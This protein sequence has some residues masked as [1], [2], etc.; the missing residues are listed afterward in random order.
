[1]FAQFPDCL[2]QGVVQNP[3]VSR[4][5]NEVKTLTIEFDTLLHSR[6]QAPKRLPVPGG[7]GA[8]AGDRVGEGLRTEF[9]GNTE[10]NRE[11]E[12]PDPQAVDAWERGDGVGVFDA[13]RCL[14]LAK[15]RASPVGCGEL[16]F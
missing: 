14:D 5:T 4:V 13:F 2:G 12:M 15:Q 1:A 10:R 7:G 3:D 8:D 16:V 11:I 9:S 6:S